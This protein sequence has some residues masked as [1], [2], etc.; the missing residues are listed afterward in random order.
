MMNKIKNKSLFITIIALFMIIVITLLGCIPISW[1]F[2]TGF[3]VG[4]VLSIVGYLLNE[5]TYGYFMTKKRKFIFSFMFGFFK[6]FLWFAIFSA[7]LIGLIFANK[8]YTNNKVSGIDGMFNIFLFLL[9]YLLYP[10]SII[11]NQIFETSK[12]LILK[13]IKKDKGRQY[14]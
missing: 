7:I 12:D 2:I 4:S 8:T 5:M 10:Q 3:L 14:E 11:I 1:T 13:K 6:F 9:G